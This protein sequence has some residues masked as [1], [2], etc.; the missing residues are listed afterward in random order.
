M[1]EDSELKIEEGG[2]GSRWNRG[3]EWE[4]GTFVVEGAVM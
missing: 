3:S 4:I 2:H 1:E